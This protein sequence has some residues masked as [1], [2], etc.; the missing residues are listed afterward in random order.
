MS[1]KCCEC[2]T[3]LAENPGVFS[4]LVSNRVLPIVLT[5]LVILVNGDRYGD[6]HYNVGNDDDGVG[7]VVDLGVS[8]VLG[9]W[10]TLGGCRTGGGTC[11]KKIRKR[12]QHLQIGDCCAPY[13]T[14]Y[15][16]LVDSKYK[17]LKGCSRKRV[18][19]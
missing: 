10:L 7:G 18:R 4:S 14:L 16:V 9:S 19:L 11:W 6:D 13:P 17:I 15:T 3:R 1:V 2:F 8:W 5:T 12:R